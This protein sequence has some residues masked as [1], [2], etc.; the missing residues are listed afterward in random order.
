MPKW[1]ELPPER[2]IKQPTQT[3]FLDARRERICPKCRKGYLLIP[4]VINCPTC[5][6]LGV[7]KFD[8]LSIIAGRRFGKSRIGS[9]AGVEEATIPNSIGWACAPTNP[10]LHRYVIP[11]FQQLIPTSWVENWNSEYL[12]L[13]LRNGSLI[14]FQ[15]LED[16]DQGRGQGLDWLWIDEVC[17]LSRKHWDVISPSLAGPGVAF[18]TTTPRGFDWVYEDFYKKAEDGVPGYWAC[19]AKTSESANPKISAE[20]LA[21]EKATK[22]DTWYRQEYEADFVTFTGAIYGESINPQILHTPTQIKEIIPEWPNIDIWRQVTVGIDTGADHPFG[23]LKLVSTEKGLVVVGEYLQRDKTFMEHCAELKRLANNPNTRW[24]INKNERQQSLELAQHGVYCQKAENDQVSGI[25]RVKSWINAKQLW[26]IAERCPKTL[27]QMMSYRWDENKSPQ[28]DQK[29]KERV[30][31]LDDEL[32]DCFIAGTKVTL[33]RGNIPI[34]QV[35][36]G[37]LALTQKGFQP[38]SCKGSRIVNTYKLILSDGTNLIGTPS[39]P[40]WSE[41]RNDFVQLN[42]LKIGEQVRTCTQTI[43]EVVTVVGKHSTGLRERVY[44][45]SVENQPEY[46]ANNILVHNCLRYALM[47][48]PILPNK[49]PVEAI[50]PRDIS[51]FSEEMQFS[52]KRMRKMD[53][54]PVLRKDGIAEDFWG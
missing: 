13:R 4:P 2:L 26:F 17:E 7:R 47:T 28:D 1:I 38:V 41:T 3:A 18:F 44:N 9:I 48:W 53:K 29:R 45:L 14:H 33:K 20:F 23:A 22:T 49:P 42:K 11:A 32:P 19:Q 43:T 35:G 30:F 5:G 8:R 6:V 50:K 27:K 16:P 37:D 10:K 54:E 36:E 21:R 46:F 25:E 52:I 39:H 34:E 12:D 31:K 24:A 15:T 51:G 40:I